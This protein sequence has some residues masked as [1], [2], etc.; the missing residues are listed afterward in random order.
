MV[1]PLKR[2]FGVVLVAG[3][4]GGED[5]TRRRRRRQRRDWAESG[6]RV[7]VV[8][9]DGDGALHSSDG[10]RLCE[11]LDRRE[12][13]SDRDALLRLDAVG[14]QVLQRAADLRTAHLG[15]DS[16]EILLLRF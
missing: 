16:I 13:R 1:D 8:L 14:D 2:R 9:S 6:G 15:V 5:C 7:V 10:F 3:Q 4:R 11:L 12:R